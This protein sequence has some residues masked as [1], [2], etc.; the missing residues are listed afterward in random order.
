LF[1]GNRRLRDSNPPDFLAP[2]AAAS[3]FV[4]KAFYR[5][6]LTAGNKKDTAESGIRLLINLRFESNTVLVFI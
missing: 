2:I 4:G 6:N 1:L 3:F 5:L